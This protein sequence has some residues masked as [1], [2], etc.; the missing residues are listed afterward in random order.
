MTARRPGLQM[1][2]VALFALLGGLAP[3]SA[4]TEE[5]TFDADEN[6]EPIAA[7]ECPAG[8]LCYRGQC[9]QAC[10]PGRERVERCARNA[11]C[12]GARPFCNESTGFCSACPGGETCVPTL[13]ICRPVSEPPDVP[14]PERPEDNDFVPDGPLDAGLPDSSGL[15][16]FPDAGEPTTG[17]EA[18]TIA[19]HLELARESRVPV[20]ASCESP[21]DPA[22]ISEPRVSVRAWNV[23]GAPRPVDAIWRP[24][25]SPAATETLASAELRDGQCEVRRID[26]ATVSPTNVGDVTFENAGFGSAVLDDW[27][28]RFEG[29]GYVASP[30]TPPADPLTFVANPR[31]A[32]VV[33]Q[34]QLFGLGRPEVTNGSFAAQLDLPFEFQPNCATLEALRDGLGVPADPTADLVFGWRDPLNGTTGQVAYVRIDAS[35]LG[36]ELVCEE[37]EASGTSAIL[38][39]ASL[40]RGFRSRLADAGGFDGGE[41]TLRFE[42]GRRNLR[43]LQVDP[44]PGQRFFATAEVGLRFV[45]TI[46]FRN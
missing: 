40:L 9:F 45:Q 37:T 12:G 34:A 1:A 41:R 21:P 15:V 7:F 43:R 35:E 22:S 32:E 2:P 33:G 46:T 31:F 24:D 27:T 28:A 39:T 10:N 11:D 19:L 42:L 30:S 20:N 25:L 23:R 3:L 5:C 8:D 16:R 18:P 14:I 38:V 36:F 26:T 13:A 29:G 17:R 4:C 6:D 44:A